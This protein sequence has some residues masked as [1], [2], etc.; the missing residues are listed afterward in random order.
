MPT[1]T[2]PTFHP[3]QTKLFWLRED[4]RAA[5]DE[6]WA[7][8]AGGQ[9][10][11]VR[12]GRRWGKTD[13]AKIWLSDSALKG[14]PV[15]YFAPSYKIMSEM[16][17]DMV[18]LLAP[19]TPKQ[20]GRNKS[21]GTIR[22]TNGGRVDFWTTEDERAGRSRMYR[23]VFWDEAAFTKTSTAM[24]VWREAIKPTLGDL[25]GT[26]VV[27][28]NTN[29][30]DPDNLL[31]ALC[32]D[33]RHGFIE[34]HA[35]SWNNPFVPRRL[36]T[37]TVE[38][39]LAVKEAYYANLR[40]REH[41]LVF[42]QEYA[43]E[44][45][46]WSGVAFFDPLKWMVDGKPVD[47]PTHCDYVYCIVDSATKT[48]SANDSTAVTWYARNRFVGHPLVILD[49]DIVQI[50]GALLEDW[51]PGVIAIG[52]ALAVQCHA[53]AGFLGAFIED[54][55]S[56]QILLQQARR[57]GLKAEAID[58]DLTAKGKDGRA[59][60]VSG[61]HYRGECKISLHAFEKHKLHKGTDRNHFYSQV[62][63]FR[64]GDKDAAKRADD[65]LDDYTYGLAVGLG[66]SEGH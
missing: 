3:D 41:P 60:S 34:F 8:N 30:N 66:D 25:R 31:Y 17:Q 55:D 65:L 13:W 61:Y 29:G 58:S 54:K 11:A 56:G 48:G 62:T 22:L 15:G 19:M 12:C 59:L 27:G 10:R 40:A 47:Y 64:I 52:E 7:A 35:P 33:P 18:R 49:W 51:L 50:E 24:D 37:E 36:P 16:Y 63:G 42:A 39:H 43:A 26:A 4:A 1:V 9:L 32:T 38:Q 5:T 46:D 14:S 44:F 2:L 53:R 21:E 20:G 28:S 6:A 57:R 23:R 45:V